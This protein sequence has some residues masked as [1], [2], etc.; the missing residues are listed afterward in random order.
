MVHIATIHWNTDKWINIQ[1]NY[2]RRYIRED[3]KIYAFLNGI[4][5]N[6]YRQNFYFVSDEEIR[7][8]EKKLNI[9]SEIILTSGKNK[10]DLIIFLDGDAFPVEP[11]MEFVYERLKKYPLLAIQRRENYLGTHLPH[12]SFCVSTIQFWEEINGNWN[13]GYIGKHLG[14]K[15]FEIGGELSQK[16]QNNKVKW[17]PLLRTHSL[18]QH[19]LWYGIYDNII[20]HHGAGFRNPVSRIDKFSLNNFQKLFF[21]FSKNVPPVFRKFMDPYKPIYQKELNESKKVYL[22]I[23]NNPDFFYFY[24]HNGNDNTEI[25]S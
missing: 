5:I 2:L 11:L 7:E 4:D 8:H 23:K 1:L 24:L 6:K 10:N 15:H 9:L 13:R 20:Y 16:L 17:Y 12:P 25:Y 18:S 19:P 3:I 22:N 14:E 21:I